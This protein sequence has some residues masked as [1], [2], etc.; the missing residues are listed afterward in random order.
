MITT[1]HE[2]S[3]PQGYHWCVIDV[4]EEKHRIRVQD[5]ATAKEP[6]R[7]LVSHSNSLVPHTAIL[8]RRSVCPWCF[9]AV[10]CC[11]PHIQ[12]AHWRP[13]ASE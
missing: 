11:G 4:L 5:V 2:H 3:Q 1:T 9:G 8:G 12:R 6:R 7:R 13:I 10:W